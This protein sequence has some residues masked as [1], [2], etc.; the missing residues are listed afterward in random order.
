MKFGACVWP[1][2]WSP[3][4]EAAIRRIAGL[5]FRAIELIAWD[6][7]T[8][9]DYYTPQ[10]IQSLRGLLNDEGLELSEFVSTPPGM[11]SPDPS[12]RAGAIEHFKRQVEVGVALGAKLINTVAPNPFELQLPR[13]TQKHLAQE[14]GYDF[15]PELDWRQ[16]WA[17]YVE[18][19]RSFCTICED[20][21]VR[22]ALEPHP[23][24]WMRNAASMMR[25][26]DHVGS[27]ALG[28]NFDPSHLFP[29]G[30]ISEM[31]IYELGD[32]VFHTHLS[33]NDGTSNVHWR[34]GKGQIDWRGVLR[35]LQAVGYN[36]VLSIELED[37]PG[38]ANARQ[39]STP[40]LDQEVLLAKAYLTQLCQELEIAVEG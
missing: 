29:M 27:P 40:A 8:L 9:D 38:V 25:L 3:P 7:Q 17:D 32:R 10:R 13:I 12:A 20:A 5:G 23:Y 28:M 14:W 36:Y 15:A 6:R 33:D 22:Y 2:Q 35:A 11:A 39:Q 24:R 18:L 19:V 16:N 34:P 31:V 30:E 4:Y 21:G 37:V 1:F 26:I